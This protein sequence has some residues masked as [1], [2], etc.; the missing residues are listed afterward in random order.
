MNDYLVK[1]KENT[2][3]IGPLSR[4]DLINMVEQNELFVT[5]YYFDK[6]ISAWVK[7]ENNEA[8]RSFLFPSNNPLKIRKDETILVDSVEKNNTPSTQEILQSLNGYNHNEENIPTVERINY[9][10]N[11]ITVLLALNGLFFIYADITDFFTAII[12]ADFYKLL[13]TP[14]FMVAIIDF[15]MAIG[16][17]AGHSELLPFIRFRAMLGLGYLAY[18]YWAFSLYPSLLAAS[19]ACCALFL[20]TITMNKT[21]IALCTL[22]GLGGMGYLTVSQLLI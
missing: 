20:I 3:P 8:L 21:T 9:Q 13:T 16:I 4:Q 1:I 12:G 14:H 22:G 17:L 7:F 5:S 10:L 19:I 2:D 11:L 6:N 15:T 18:S